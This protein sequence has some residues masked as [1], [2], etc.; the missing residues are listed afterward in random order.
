[1]NRARAAC[2][3]QSISGRSS[4]CE[5]QTLIACPHR[6]FLCTSV[7]DPGPPPPFVHHSPFVSGGDVTE[8]Q[9]NIP[10]RRNVFPANDWSSITT[11]RLFFNDALVATDLKS[12]TGDCCQCWPW[13]FPKASSA[14][15]S[16]PPEGSEQRCVRHPALRADLLGP[17]VGVGNSLRPAKAFLTQR[18]QC[19]D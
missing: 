5:E 10:Q 14:R 9:S 8:R 6:R 12:R 16:R 11:W 4:R 2:R 18:S 1:M 7:S 17:R 15:Q 19:R 13:S 3:W